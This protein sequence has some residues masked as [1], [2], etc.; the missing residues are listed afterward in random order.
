MKIFLSFLVGLSFFLCDMSHV[1]FGATTFNWSATWDSKERDLS[2]VEGASSKA[3]YAIQIPGNR[4]DF[5]G[6]L[7][8]FRS[9]ET[10]KLV[11]FAQISS[12]IMKGKLVDAIAVSVRTATPDVLFR[13]SLEN[14]NDPDKCSFQTELRSSLDFETQSFGPAD[15]QCWRRGVLQPVTRI[16]SFAEIQSIQFLVTRSGQRPPLASSETLTPFE[17]Q[18]SELSLK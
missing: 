12:D 2:T 18:V 16:V 8:W 15:F 17:L 10:A 9:R 13:L 1:L 5:F 7:G 6:F 4:L 14:P 11:G 3:A